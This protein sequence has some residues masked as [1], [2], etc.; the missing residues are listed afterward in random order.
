[1]PLTASCKGRNQGISSILLC[2]LSQLTVAILAPELVHPA[3]LVDFVIEMSKPEDS[4]GPN[5]SGNYQHMH[6]KQT[7]YSGSCS[8]RVYG[9]SG[10]RVAGRTTRPVLPAGP[11]HAMKGTVPV[12]L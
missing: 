4:H 3:A 10:T 1:M 7:M 12:K 8:M 5:H 9:R 11:V 2:D 6:N